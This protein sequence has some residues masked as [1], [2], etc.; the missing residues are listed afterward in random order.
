MA[1]PRWSSA[2]ATTDACDRAA[3]PALDNR[4]S[5]ANSGRV[6]S[7]GTWIDR[8]TFA[9]LAFTAGA[10]DDAPRVDRSAAVDVRL[11]TWNVWFGGHMF[12][13]RRDALI[14]EL[15][16]RR[17]DVVAL[18]EVTQELLDPLLEEPWLR[19]AYQVSEREVAM[20]DVVVLSRL[21][22]RRMAR[23]ALPTDMGRRLVIA[24]LACGLTIAT[25]HLESTRE[26]APARAAQLRVIQPALARHDDVALVG[27]MN[28]QPGDPLETAVLDPALIDVW[29]ALR[30]DEPG[31]TVDTDVNTMRMQVKST[32]V[33]KRIDRVFVRSPR[34]RARSI[35]LVGTRPIDIDGTFISDHF[36]LA[37]E[38]AAE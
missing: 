34:W 35:E 31:Y 9:P 5:T 10:W 23:V 2:P 12:D 28:F 20:Y 21:P 3:R 11:L 7:Q 37:A 19:A 36:G 18:Q 29:P 22:I 38:L 1:W 17:P 26:E 8:F 24:E 33:R 25:V 16:R 27:D 15:E 6:T 13:E 4:A 14:A 30:P 32:P